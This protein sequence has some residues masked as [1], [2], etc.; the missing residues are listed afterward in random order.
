MYIKN[1]SIKNFK[2]ISDISIDFQK[3]VN[4]LIGD[5]GVGKSSILSAIVVALGGFFQGVTG[6]KAKGITTD[7]IRIV[8]KNLTEDSD[9]IQYQFPVKIMST[10]DVFGKEVKYR[11]ERYSDDKIKIYNSLKKYAVDIT[12]DV[13]SFLPIL[14]YQSID[15]ESIDEVKPRKVKD[16][17][18]GYYRC[19]ESTI[20]LSEITNWCLEMEISAFKKNKKIPEY[21]AFRKIISSFMKYMSE[22]KTDPEICY[23]RKYEELSY[24]EDNFELPISKLSAGYQSLLYMILDIAYRLAV[25][26]PAFENINEAE[27]VILIDEIDLHLHPKWQWRVIGALEKVL[28]NIQFIVATH[29]PII[30]SSCKNEILI[31]ID[32]NQEITY[33]EN[34][35]AY[36]IQDVLELRQGSSGIPVEL[37]TLRDEL[38]ELINEEQYD[39]AKKVWDNMVYKFGKDNS[40]VVNAKWLLNLEDYN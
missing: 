6:I 33:L 24:I 7:D 14:S 5:N 1:I 30:I 20:N 9:A 38:E 8:Q 26:N 19:L 32:D 12:N 29:S 21:E 10:F 35:Y 28:P 37:Q 34:A 11:R 3:G 18:D 23:S 39:S 27:G 22:L 31:C 2:G 13:K 17:R 4:L 16:R 40:E 25:L 36:S 15:R